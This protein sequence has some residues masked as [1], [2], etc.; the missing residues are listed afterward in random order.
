LRC[1]DRATR[2]AYAVS[3]LGVDALLNVPRKR[4]EAL[5]NNRPDHKIIIGGKRNVEQLSIRS[6][7]V[8]ILGDVL[9]RADGKTADAN[10]D[11]IRH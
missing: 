11:F 2:S 9:E 6:D 1:R 8:P 5:R 7:D 4:S 10:R 3:E